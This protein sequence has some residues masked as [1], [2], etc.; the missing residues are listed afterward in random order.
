MHEVGLKGYMCT[1]MEVCL[2]SSKHMIE[3]SERTW[4]QNNSMNLHMS[5]YQN[6][7]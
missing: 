3:I 7:Y 2:H 1:E 5:V 6:Y 4:L